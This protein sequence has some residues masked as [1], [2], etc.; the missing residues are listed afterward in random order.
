MKSFAR[1]FELSEIGQVL[2]TC[3]PTEK[4]GCSFQVTFNREDGPVTADLAANPDGIGFTYEQ[5]QQRL[6]ELHPALVKEIYDGLQEL[7]TKIEAGEMPEG[8]TVDEPA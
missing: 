1:L 5:C 7:I 3:M 4:G 2:F 8:V 6:E